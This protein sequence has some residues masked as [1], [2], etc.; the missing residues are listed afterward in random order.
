MKEK[1][2]T[3]CFANK[4]CNKLLKIMKVSFS[5]FFL[6]IFTM[7]AEN[8]YPQQA[9]V[10][11]N[12]KNVT[13]KKA[14]TEIEKES[15]YVFLIVDEAKSELDA[16]TSIQAN[17]E[18]INNILERIF[19]DTGLGYNIVERQVSVYKDGTKTK[20]ESKEVAIAVAQQQKKKVTGVITDD[21]GES[22]IG[23]NIMEKGTTNGIVTDFYGN[24]TLEVGNNAIL[25]I[26]YIG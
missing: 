15:D 19:S 21:Y 26:S 5:L 12:L 20:A 22:I 6:C 25:Q 4:K 8:M 3:D 23:A 2:K 1:I 11:L 24:L 7:T 16:K 13:L 18:S 14:I 9:E 17:K 10:S